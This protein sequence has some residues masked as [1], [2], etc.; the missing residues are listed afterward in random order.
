MAHGQKTGGRAL[1]TPNKVTNDARQAIASFVDGNA[2]RL[3]NWLDRVADGVKVQDPDSGAER[4]IVAPN[5]A[6]AFDMFQSVIEYH[7]PKLGRQEMTLQGV[8]GGAPFKTENTSST[9]LF[10]AMLNL[11]MTKRAG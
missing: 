1:G 11:E 2:H 4:Y 6:K 5:P 3:S 8:E 10:E 7:I 9:I